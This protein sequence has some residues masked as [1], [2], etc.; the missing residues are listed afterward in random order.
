MSVTLKHS[1]HG[2]VLDMTKIGGI[3]AQSMPTGTEVQND[4]DSGQINATFQAVIAQKHI[5]TFSTQAVGTTLT[6]IG[7]QGWT[8]AGVFF[9][10]YAQKWAAGAGRASGSVHN[11]YVY[12]N[13]LVVPESLS[14]AHGENA[15]LSCIGHITFD[16]SNSPIVVTANNVLVTGFVENERFGLGPITIAGKTIANVKSIELSFGLDVVSDG[17]DG[18]IWDTFV[19][20]RSVQPILT[21]RGTQ[22]DIAESGNFPVGGYTSATQ[23]IAV[24]TPCT[25]ANTIFYLRK[26]TASGYVPKATVEHIKFTMAGYAHVETMMDASGNDAGDATLIVTSFNDGSLDPLVYALS[27]LP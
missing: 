7:T 21:I 5:P 19:S 16:G 10:M 9:A 12:R 23:V 1:L 4:P 15:S 27:A 6:K 17:S 2:V 3:T 20:L 14:V 8:I 24:G 13:G 18:D 11:K 25:H 26:R 22:L